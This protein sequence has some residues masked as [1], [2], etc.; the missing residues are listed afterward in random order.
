MR[1]KLTPIKPANKINESIVQGLIKK[2]GND[3]LYEICIKTG[4]YQGTFRRTLENPDTWGQA[5]LLYK[6]CKHLGLDMIKVIEN[7]LKSSS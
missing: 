6:I 3:H 5:K 7:E 1:P 2:Q 4:Q